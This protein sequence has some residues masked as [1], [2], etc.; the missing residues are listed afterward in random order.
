[1]K[2]SR[3]S[4]RLCFLAL[5]L[6]ATTALTAKPVSHNLDIH[7]TLCDNG[8]AEITEVRQMSIDNEGTECYIV[9]GNLNGSDISDFSVYD[10]TGREFVNEGAWDVD[11]SRMRKAGRCGIVDK[12]NGYELCWGLGDAGERIYFVKYKVTQLVR[13]YDD[14]DGF[15]YMFVTRN[16]SPAPQKATVTIRA[17]WRENGLPEDSIKIWSFGYHGDIIK[18][19]SIVEA[20][21][22][23]PL[24][25][26]SSMIVMM[27]LEK[28]I[29]HPTKVEG[30][31]FSNVRE[32]AFVDSDYE[33]ESSNES[34]G[35]FSTIRDNIEAFLG[36]LLIFFTLGCVSLYG[37]KMKRERKKMLKTVDWYRDIPVN[38][39]LLRAKNLYNAFYFSGGLSTDNLLSAM[40]LRL[41]RGGALR[42]EKCHVAATGFKKMFGGKGKDMD[43]IVI[44]DFDASNRLMGDKTL[45]NLY[46]IFKK[47]SGGDRILQ[48]SELERWFLSNKEESLLFL[49]SLDNSVS[50][51]EAKNSID[52]VRKVYGLKKFL[53]DFTLANEHHLSEVALW[54]DYL[55]YATLYG[56]AD[57]VRKDME[58]INPEYLKMDEIART[59]TNQKVVPLLTAATLSSA[60]SVKSSGSRGSGG[61]GS[62]SFGGGG[63]FSG[64]GS[65]GG[66]R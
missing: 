39:N 7:V 2:H 22:T 37:L 53:E 20:T 29:L 21:T 16:I 25:G 32:T 6:A 42:I 31:S 55:V 41:L 47:A 52:D 60:H 35:V 24:G 19:D 58:K 23:E 63:G 59:L 62:S 65:G 10:E 15:N 57:Q 12:Q 4:F 38:G 66:V 46:D 9:I 17:P 28:G 27:E 51:K 64:G 40:V 26:G 56:I 50:L 44:G 30:G 36:L 14:S 1:M 45:H 48:P 5:L 18:V 49:K 34:K 61:G 3:N 11:R 8:D 54:N 33:I 43:C 13:S